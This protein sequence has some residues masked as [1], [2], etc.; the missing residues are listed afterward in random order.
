MREP[1]G[2]CEVQESPKAGH[3][4][5]IRAAEGALPMNQEELRRDSLGK[6]IG[7]IVTAVFI[8]SLAD[9]AVKYFSSRLPLWQLFLVVSC[10]S[11]PA[12]GSWA[13]R[14]IHRGRLRTA[15]LRWLA[16]RSLLLLLMWVSYYAALP[17]IPLS[18]AA[19]AIY[20][21]PLFIALFSTRY[22]GESLSGMGWWAIGLGFAGV[23]LVLRPGADAF[24]LAALLPVAGAVFYALAMVV[25]RRHCRNEHPLVL[26]LALNV[27]FLMAACAGGVASLLIDTPLA[28][29]A[30]FLL[31]AW[32]PLDGAALIF[33]V[34]Y[35][36][37]LVF[38]NTATARAYQVA[39]AALIG[40]FDYAYLPFACLWGYLVFQEVPDLF[41]WGGMLLILAAGLLILFAQRTYRS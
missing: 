1:K 20:T 2:L 30:G 31:A 34:L 15:A 10:L 16:L 40:T 35:A 8:L 9:A 39:P 5:Q 22:G 36:V 12:L 33:I 19:V 23:V 11:V 14:R 24:A 28:A 29:R 21:T 7:L 18:V 6:G 32:Q 26:A 13:V 17:F 4:A 25:T 37:A 27:A 3:L 41:T 38:V